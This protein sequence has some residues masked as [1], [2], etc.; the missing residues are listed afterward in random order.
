MIRHINVGTLAL[1]ASLCGGCAS[2]RMYPICFYD[3]KP[4]AESLDRTYVPALRKSFSAVAAGKPDDL[5]V[6]PDVRWIIAS[7]TDS[8][9]ANLLKMWPRLGCIGPAGSTSQVKLQV[10]CIAYVEDFIKEKKY[11]ELG[12]YKGPSGNTYYNESRDQGRLVYC[13]KQD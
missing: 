6:S 3:K 1:L 7:T 8:Q 2:V 11:T 13:A 9:D 5:A 10:D 12:L 4:D